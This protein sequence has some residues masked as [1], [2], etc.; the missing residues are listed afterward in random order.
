M[1]GYGSNEGGKFRM[2]WVER[3]RYVGDRQELPDPKN[4]LVTDK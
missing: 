1:R 4:S 3:H 2:L